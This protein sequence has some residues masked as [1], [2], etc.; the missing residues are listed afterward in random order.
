[1]IDEDIEIGKIVINS[2]KSHVGAGRAPIRHEQPFNSGAAEGGN[3][4]VPGGK[5]GDNGSM[6]RER[7]AQKRGDATLDHGKVTQPDRVQLKRGLAWR[8]AFRFRRG[9]VAIGIRSQELRRDERRSF[10]RRCSSKRRPEQR[11]VGKLT[12]GMPMHFIVW[13]PALSLPT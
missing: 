5:V 1:M 10:N 7:R 3:E 11:R 6:Q 8:G 12:S 9:E 13:M 2:E 4:T